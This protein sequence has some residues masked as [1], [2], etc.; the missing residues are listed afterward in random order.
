MIVVLAALISGVVGP[1][2]L[3]FLKMKYD[4]MQKPKDILNDTI[5]NSTLI[6]H[7]LEEIQEETNCDRIWLAQFH[8]GGHFYPTGKSIQKF[9]IFYELVNP[10]IVSIQSNFQNIPVNLFGKAMN[11]LIEHDF[12]AIDDSRNELSSKLGLNSIILD[13]GCRSL[14]FFAVKSIDDKFIGFI[15][16]S[17]GKK[18]KL[19][20]TEINKLLNEVSLIGG[21][22]MNHLK[23]K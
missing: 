6:T 5:E 9:S 7:K 22:L 4:K 13:A 19:N 17:F 14:Y 20:E 21:T 10:G 23:L 3:H 15:G 16:L 2:I 8:N 1:V 18:H 11:D 12:I